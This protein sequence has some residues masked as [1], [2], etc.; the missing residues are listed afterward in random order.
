MT[1]EIPADFARES[2]PED[3]LPAPLERYRQNVA[4]SIGSP[5][6][7]A[8]AAMLGAASV[9]IGRG[10]K[11]MVTPTWEMTPSLFIAVV[12]N[13]GSGK[14]P[15]FSQILQPLYDEQQERQQHMEPIDQD[16]VIAALDRMLSGRRCVRQAHHWQMS[17]YLVLSDV[18]TAAM[19]ERMQENPR[20]LLV[21]ADELAAMFIRS[22][23]GA[24]R[25]WWCTAFDGGRPLTKHRKNH[26]V[27]V[28]KPFVS[29]IGGIQPDLVSTLRSRR[30]ED[31][32]FE[33]FLFFGDATARL[34]GGTKFHDVDHELVETWRLA[35]VALLGVERCRS[36]GE[37]VRV[38]FSEEANVCREAFGD[39]LKA[40]FVAEKVSPKHDGVA[41]KLMT[42]AVRLAFIRR[43]LRWSVGEFGLS[44]PVGPVTAEDFEAACKV[45]LFSLRRLVPWVPDFF[46]QTVDDLASLILKF[47]DARG[48]LAITVRELQ[49][50]KFQAD[51]KAADLRAACQ[52]L[53]AAG[54]GRWTE[55][56]KLF[57]LN[58]VELNNPTA[59]P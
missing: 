14:S 53:V 44:G 58:E 2:F 42:H 25:Q 18:S 23:Q 43:C 22:G 54:R 48:L 11:A 29:L 24:D 33:R 30:G 7:F 16:L 41:S 51:L 5:S 32:L 1:R 6:E 38:V 47:M 8:A 20:G 50:S 12:G 15:T 34:L 56:G 36:D 21:D 35:I 26:V 13:K 3:F 40:W 9:A 45:V 39:R 27:Q 37:P 17:P 55:N 59:Q 10:V 4:A 31:G 49:Q 28:D 46:E 19:M 52:G 57:C